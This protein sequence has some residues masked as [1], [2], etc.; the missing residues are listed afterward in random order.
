MSQI[1]ARRGER[2]VAK[3]GLDP[4]LAR[5]KGHAEALNIKDGKI[6]LPAL[7]EAFPD[8]AE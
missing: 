6:V 8:L 5:S 3:L 1:P 4:F 7:L 2:A